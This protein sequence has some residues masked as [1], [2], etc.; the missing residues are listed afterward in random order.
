MQYADVAVAERMERAEVDLVDDDAQ[1]F[2]PSSSDLLDG[3]LGEYRLRRQQIDQLAAIIGGDIGNAVHYFIQ[4]NA[5]DD[6]LHR[7]IYLDRLFQVEGAVHALDAAYWSRALSLTDVYECMPQDRKNAW[8]EQLKHPAGRKEDRHHKGTNG[9]QPLPHFEEETVRNTIGDLLRMRS[10]FLAEKVDGIFRALS[11]LHVTNAPEA[12][13]KRMIIAGVLNSYSSWAYERVGYL[14]DLRCVIAKFMGRDEPKHQGSTNALVEEAKR[15][16]GKWVVADG[17][18][19]KIRVYKVGT[20]HME[21]HPDMAWRL[22]QILAHL[23]PLA[24]PAQFRQQPKRRPKEVPVMGR[25]LPFAVLDLLS[26]RQHYRG[27]DQL[28]TF[29]FDYQAKEQGA[30][31]QEACRVLSS[32]GGT[33]CKDT[34][35]RW[36]FDFPIAEV[37]SELLTTGCIPDKQAHQFF[38]TPDKLA[39]ICAELAEICEFDTVLEPS[40]GQGDLAQFLPKDRTTCVEISP[41]HCAVLKAKGFDTVQA[42]FIAWSQAALQFSAVVMNPPFSDGRAQSHVQHAAL[43]VKPGGRLVAI[44][45]ASARGKD[46]LGDV[47]TSEWSGVYEREFAGTG[48]AVVI[49]KAVRK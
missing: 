5:G 25:P 48:A 43:M 24:I 7:S 27:P 36:V 10:Q 3:L 26:A 12:F 31:Y 34:E 28:R 38:P 13:G 4:G 40:A 46:W 45:P 41:L 35:S 37:F 8:N 39:R 19:I 44:L 22:N 20:A 49:L 6:Q 14:H 47:W 21:V 32:L 29:T 30:V 33:P 1:F 16:S 23:Y 11:G 15:R 9:S 2:A 17:G 18:A 42:D